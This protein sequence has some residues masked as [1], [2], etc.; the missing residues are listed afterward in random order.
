[1][2]TN[3]VIISLADYNQL[4]EF[5]ERIEAGFT[6]KCPQPVYSSWGICTGHYLP[7]INYIT[8]DTA[9]EEVVERYRE[10]MEVNQRQSDELCELRNRLAECRR[11]VVKMSV[12]EF[13][14]WRKKQNETR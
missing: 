12:W 9:I 4:R 1:M 11:D 3:T 2:Q 7:A 13:I 10:L 5:K 14:K 6:H 8:T